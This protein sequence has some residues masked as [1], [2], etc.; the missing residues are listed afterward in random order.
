M[1][2]PH[3]LALHLLAVTLAVP[4]LPAE[5][6]PLRVGRITIDA[7]PLFDSEEAARGS[8][9]RAANI[10]HVQ[11]KATLLRR[12]LLFH[13]GDPYDAAQLEETERNLRLF[14]FLKRVSVTPS[15]PHDGVVDVNVT[16]QDE[17][18]SSVT[19]DY[20]NDGGIA[21]Y[22]IDF[23]Q[24]DLAGTGSEFQV[25]LDHGVERSVRAFEFLHPA[26]FGPYWNLDAV[27][28]KNSDGDE[29]RLV[30]DRPLYS[31]ATPWAASFRYEHSLRND[32]IFS[33]GEVAARFR[34]RHRELELSRSHVL[35]NDSKGSSQIVAGVDLLD[36]TFSPLPDRTLDVIPLSRRFRFIDF[37]YE[38]THFKFVK[39][40]YVDRD[41]LEQDFNLGRY[42][43]VHGAVSPAGS[44][45]PVTWRFSAS[46][47]LGHAFGKRSFAIG[48][49]SA[50]TRA[51]R[52][53][54]TVI[55][56]DG[57]VIARFSTAHPQAFV[58]RIR[59][60]RG[61]QLDRDVQFLADGQNGLR[62]YP[63]FSFEGDRRIIINA[64]HRLFLGRELLQLFAPGVAV[65]ADSGIAS[66]SPIS[67]GK[68]KT[69]VGIGVRIAIARYASALIR[70]D[71]AYALDAGPLNRRGGTFS[72][73]TMH[74]F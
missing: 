44:G 10:L 50:T 22:D 60:D 59:M 32:R 48:Q 20:S 41:L 52:N 56:F 69:D 25:H 30:L 12:F 9:Y 18:T 61:W 2:I 62:A 11:T 58:A 38:S 5:E 35:R 54:N 51:P 73:A 64:E 42:T 36:D 17:W 1:R 23:A 47:G 4:S 40:D 28:S 53:R 16:T 70:I 67:P 46:E 66:H 15:A 37:G 65:F 31:Y 49:F 71:Y 14:D 57:R 29:E 74:A 26:L 13:E 27:Y 7:M 6:K 33:E 63:D 34:R 3:I 39:I 8:F 72:I 19:G 55:S 68:M 45:M 21:T 24:K 43:T